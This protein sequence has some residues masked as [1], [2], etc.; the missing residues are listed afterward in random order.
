MTTTRICP[1]RGSL[2]PPVSLSERLLLPPSSPLRRL[3]AGGSSQFAAPQVQPTPPPP[4]PPC[5]PSLKLVL[6]RGASAL[7]SG[8]DLQL[9]RGL[10]RGV[11]LSAPLWLHVVQV[12]AND[13]AALQRE[14]GAV[15]A[16]RMRSMAGAARP[17]VQMQA[18]N[19]RCN[20]DRR[21]AFLFY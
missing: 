6:V 3:V 20:R 1:H 19:G 10:L 17:H 16:V 2:S 9:W 4:P 7:S 13:A 5:H 11:R 12:D 18:P 15:D 14:I 21:T 8:A